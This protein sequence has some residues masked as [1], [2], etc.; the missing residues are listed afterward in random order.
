MTRSRKL[1]TAAGIVLAI[2][3]TVVMAYSWRVHHSFSFAIREKGPQACQNRMPCVF[4]LGEIFPGKWDRIIV[5]DMAANQDEVDGAVGQHLPRP[6][7]LRFIVFMQG[8]NVLRTVE[9]SQGVERPQSDE[10]LIADAPK[11]QNHVVI[12]RDALF[13]MAKGYDECDDCTVIGMLKP[14]QVVE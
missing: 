7:L 4:N 1:G 11:S 8:P 9:E 5:F 13:V 2:V 6:D 12:D 10:V 14:G 3:L